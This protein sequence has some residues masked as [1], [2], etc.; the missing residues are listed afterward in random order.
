MS[1]RTRGPFS[2][3]GPLALLLGGLA[4]LAAGCRSRKVD[5]SVPSLVKTLHDKDPNVRY[6]A[7]QSLGHLGAEAKPA[8]PALIEALGDEDAMV[9]MGAAYALA[10]IG[11]DASE[12]VPALRGRLQDPAPEVRKAA[13]YALP[14]VQ[15]KKR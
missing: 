10:E 7:A 9:R 3:A 5:Y 14:R 4:L 11:P 12:S 8:V 1:A 2:A 15:A 13:A 6:W